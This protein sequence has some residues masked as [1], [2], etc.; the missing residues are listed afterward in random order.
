MEM[1]LNM[2]TSPAKA[3]HGQMREEHHHYQGQPMKQLHLRDKTQRQHHRYVVVGVHPQSGD[4]PPNQTHRNHHLSSTST[5]PNF[6]KTKTTPPD[7][8]ESKPEKK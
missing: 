8:P 1:K 2:N 5:D 7:P 4:P 6:R 3:K